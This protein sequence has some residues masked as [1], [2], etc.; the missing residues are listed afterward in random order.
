[1]TRRMLLSQ[2]WGA[3]YGA[4]SR[5]LHISI[6]QLRLKIEP[7]PASPHFSLTVPGVGS[8]LTEEP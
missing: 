6:G 1:M 2:I 7:D 4:V 8:R 5:Y 3:D